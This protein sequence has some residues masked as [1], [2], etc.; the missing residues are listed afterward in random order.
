MKIASDKPAS[1]EVTGIERAVVKVAT[2]KHAVLKRYFPHTL[3]S[4]IQPDVHLESIIGAFIRDSSCDIEIGN[5][6]P[7]PWQKL[8]A[9]NLWCAASGVFGADQLRR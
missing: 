2:F 5:N 9:R 6:R 1:R 3:I 7:I 8:L 4:A